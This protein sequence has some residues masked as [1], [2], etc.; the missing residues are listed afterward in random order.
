MLYSERAT[1][2]NFNNFRSLRQSREYMTRRKKGNVSIKK[3]VEYLL[4]ENGGKI[5]GTVSKCNRNE[6]RDS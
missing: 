2:R 6:R 4:G 3:L 5:D 1:I